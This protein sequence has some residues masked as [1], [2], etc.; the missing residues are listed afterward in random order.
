MKQIDLVS[1]IAKHIKLCRPDKLIKIQQYSIQFFIVSA[2]SF[3][4]IKDIQEMQISPVR[5]LFSLSSLE[6]RN[7]PD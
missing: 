6:S 4:R 7:G 3:L 1:F 2:C 5:E